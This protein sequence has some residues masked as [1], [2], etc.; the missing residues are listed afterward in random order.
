M[1][2]SALSLAFIACG[3]VAAPA[4]AEKPVVAVVE[5]E[6]QSGA[7]WWRGGVGW[8]L[9][10]MLSNELQATNAFRVVE[11]DQLESVLE[12]Q[13]L[14]ASGRVQG[15]T[16]AKIGKLVGAQYLIAGTVTAYEEETASTG[17]GVSFGGVSLG[18]SSEKAYLAVDLRVINSTTGEVEFSR[19]IEGTSK[20][21]GMSIGVYRGGFGGTLASQ[22]KTPAGKAIRAALVEITDYLECVMVKQ[23]DRCLSEFEAKE[24]RRREKTRGSLDLDE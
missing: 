1:R 17:G 10:G 9:A 2:K 4:F 15:G 8:E 13:N 7:G 18:G 19:S 12:E 16:G 22:N 21:G 3:L 23:T 5:F 6:N 24:E 14:A 20:G 11:R